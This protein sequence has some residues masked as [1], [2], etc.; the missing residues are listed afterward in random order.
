[1]KHSLAKLVL[2]AHALREASYVPMT[3][4][5]GSDGR[6]PNGGGHYERSYPEA[7]EQAANELRVDPDLLPVATLMFAY[8]GDATDWAEAI[9]LKPEPVVGHVI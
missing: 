6:I 5:E 7:I 8:V 2:R 9:M 3:F 1:M 4:T